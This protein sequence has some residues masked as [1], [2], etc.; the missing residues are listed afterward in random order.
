VYFVDFIGENTFTFSP[1]GFRCKRVTAQNW[2]IDPYLKYC[3]AE[4]PGDVK[5][6]GREW[7]KLKEKS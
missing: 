2:I 1:R 7:E 3:S 4:T 5:G 6:K